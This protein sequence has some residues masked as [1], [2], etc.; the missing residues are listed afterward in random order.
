MLQQN[1]TAMGQ[2]CQM[3]KKGVPENACDDMEYGLVFVL[4]D[5]EHDDKVEVVDASDSDDVV[6]DKDSLP[7]RRGRRP[8]CPQYTDLK[9]PCCCGCCCC[10]C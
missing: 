5:E 10:C 1:I 8:P 4:D 9:D 7:V 6:D 2:A 3:T